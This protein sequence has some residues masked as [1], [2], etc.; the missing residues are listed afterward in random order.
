MQT[1]DI[2]PVQVR[3][4]IL[5]VVSLLSLFGVLV[6]ADVSDKWIAV[7]S[8]FVTALP[9]ILIYADAVI[10]KARAYNASAIAA[11][12]AQDELLAPPG[13]TSFGRDPLP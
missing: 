4:V 8:G 3:A 6:P 11:S 12:K 5:W 9:L 13:S 2:T 10:R 7:G 1:P